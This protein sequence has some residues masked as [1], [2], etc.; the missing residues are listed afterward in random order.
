MSIAEWG[1]AAVAVSGAVGTLIAAA[2]QPADV[3]AL[4]GEV[5]TARDALPADIK[6]AVDAVRVALEGSIG[7]VRTNLASVARR[8][9]ELESWRRT[10]REA[11]T[12]TGRHTIVS[13]SDLSAQVDKEHERRI[14]ALETRADKT[15]ARAER[16]DTAM[17]EARVSL[18]NVLGRLDAFVRGKSNQ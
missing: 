12:E 16:M 15:D 10:V 9:G 14:L 5:K 13:G 17:T 18:G 8:V 3:T 1:A 11:A 7:E 6:T 2:R 4:R